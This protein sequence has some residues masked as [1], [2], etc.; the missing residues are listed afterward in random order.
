MLSNHDRILLALAEL[1]ARV[2]SAA[3]LVVACWKKYPQYFSLG[4]HPHP[5][6]N[7][8]LCCLMGKKGLVSQGLLARVGA[9]QYSLT[10]KG[11]IRASHLAGSNGEIAVQKP[12]LSTEKARQR[13]RRNGHDRL[14]LEDGDLLLRLF[15][16]EATNLWELGRDHEIT[17]AMILDF[18]GLRE[19][20]GEEGMQKEIRRLQS[21]LDSIRLL[22]VAGP[23]VLG[24]GR[25]VCKD[26]VM[27]LERLREMLVNRL[28]SAKKP[29]S[30]A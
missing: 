21:R 14:P 8:V 26:D 18:L 23:V 9:K 22:L 15:D 4:G 11:T 1:P 25:E 13:Y 2:I 12:A 17:I 16:E 30:R 5:D 6:S 3:D 7:R 10:G 29:R 24:N 27:E 20:D 19:V 28:A